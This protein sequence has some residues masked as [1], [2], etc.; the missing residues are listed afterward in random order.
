MSPDP[1]PGAVLYAKDVELARAFYQDVLGLEPVDLKSDHVVLEAPMFQLV[2]L[3]IPAAVASSIKVENP[4]R[5]RAE[6]PIKLV[7][8]VGSI[9]DARAAAPARGGEFA[10]REREWEFQGCRVCDGHDPEGNVVQV[11][12]RGLQ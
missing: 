12:E 2:I 6:T 7:F 8:P 5:R 9:A 10:P 11:R 1:K 3:E 4:P